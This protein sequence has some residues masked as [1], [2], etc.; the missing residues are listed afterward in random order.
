MPALDERTSLQDS[1]AMTTREPLLLI[2]GF[3]DTGRTW[4]P[5]LP[6]LA[7]RFEVITPTLLG[8]HG[9]AP[10]P[11]QMDDPLSAMADD[12]EATLDA[13]GLDRLPVV[14]SSLGGWLGFALAS[15][16]R[17]TS[18]LALAPAQGWLEDQPPA[19]TRR[20]F[21]RAHRMAPVGA[22]HAPRIARRSALRRLAFADIIA[23]PERVPPATAQALIAG[24]ADCPMYEPF[25]AFMADGRYRDGWAEVTV[26][27][28]IAWGDRDRTI[29]FK[30]CSGWFRDRLP[31]ARWV[32]LPDCG[33]LPHHDD[34]ELVSALIAEV[35]GAPQADAPRAAA[36]A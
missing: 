35:A 13:A 31:E 19:R 4:D 26:P 10:I 27:T 1:A 18:V 15:R 29:P 20:Q 6:H 17:A 16:G 5:L 30:R 32:R 2:H 14:G 8:H 34:P 11:E 36:A 7:D 33:H 25:F 3:T 28:V 24:A 22:R 12:L 21:A 23:H 9:G